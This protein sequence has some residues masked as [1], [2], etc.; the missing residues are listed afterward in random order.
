[1][2]QTKERQGAAASTGE[3]KQV[4][5]WASAFSSGHIQ[6]TEGLLL[7]EQNSPIKLH[8]HML[9]LGMTNIQFLFFLFH[10]LLDYSRS[11]RLMIH[12]T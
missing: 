11:L 10:I 2:Y 12:G 3:Y 8:H 9:Q 4:E 5:K 6:P 1:M 7:P